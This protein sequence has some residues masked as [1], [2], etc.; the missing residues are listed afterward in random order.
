MNSE[1]VKILLIEDDPRD[2]HLL[3]EAIAEVRESLCEI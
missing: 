2:A 3:S 1:T